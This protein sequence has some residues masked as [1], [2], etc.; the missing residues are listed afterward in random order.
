VEVSKLT[1]KEIF[2]RD[3]HIVVPIYQRPY[4]WTKDEQWEPLWNDIRLLAEQL[5]ALYPKSR[6]AGV[7]SFEAL[8]FP[9]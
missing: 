2:G 7:P 9:T 6:R 3:R 5:R 4:V 8:D 1:T